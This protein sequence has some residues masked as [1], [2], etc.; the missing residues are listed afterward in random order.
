MRS[1]RVARNRAVETVFGLAVLPP[2]A[3]RRFDSDGLWRLVRQCAAF[4]SGTPQPLHNGLALG[5]SRH[6]ARAAMTTSGDRD[7]RAG[8]SLSVAAYLAWGAFPLYFKALTATPLEV[9]ANRVVW[10]ALF[11]AL[12]LAARG[13]MRRVLSSVGSRRV[14]LGSVLSAGLLALNWFVYIWAVGE[15]RVVDAS[16]GYF[17][18]PLFSVLVGVVLLE[19]SL[20]GGQRL[21]IATA[22]AG[23]AWLTFHFGQLPWVGLALAVTFGSYGALRKTGALGALEGLM[24]EQLLMLPFAGGLLAW[25]LWRGESTLFGP[26]PAQSVLLALSGPL[27]SIPLLSFAAGA[28]R[29][30]LSLVGVL[31]YISPTLQ[32]L[33]GIFVWHEPFTPARFAGYALIWLA[34]LIYSAEG[35]WAARL[36]RREARGA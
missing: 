22:A 7:R 27:S 32:L 4:S 2:A 21:A 34:L 13:R 33:L 20:R 5:A 6:Y 8:I 11:L 26:A 3:E 35:L 30:P 24:L 16:L 10:S 15:R 29:I 36:R 23:V 12:V 1:R 19:E 9:L 18:T 25:L 31:Q 28:R 14:V 17:I